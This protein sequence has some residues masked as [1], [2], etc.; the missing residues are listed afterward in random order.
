MAETS[1][2]AVIA[3]A[4]PTGLTAALALAQAGWR[5]SVIEQAPVMDEVGAGLQIPPNASRILQKLGVMDHLRPLASEPAALH[6]RRGRDGAVLARLP[7]GSDAIKRWGA[8]SLVVHR[9]DLQR[10]LLESIALKPQISV[11]TGTRIMGF[12]QQADGIAIGAKMGLISIKLQADL[13]IG[14]DG[15]R[16]LLRERLNLAP[17]DQPHYS[18]R[19]AWRA[20]L[21]A[22]EAPDFAKSALTHLW[23]GS[24][25]HLVHYP[26]RGGRL[27]NIVAITQDDWRAQDEPDLWASEGASEDV[28][29]RFKH[30][31]KEARAL[32]HAVRCWRRWPLY[33]RTRLAHWSAGH[34]VLA[35]DA[36]HPM[37][38][39]L[40][41]GA[42]QGIEDGYALGQAAQHNGANLSRLIVDYESKRIARAYRVQQQSRQQGV[43]YHLPEPVAMM[44]DLTLRVLGPQRLQQRFD[45]LYAP[46]ET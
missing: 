19:I 41:Q 1:L 27:I 40:A 4:G 43:I 18:G 39:F 8:P 44:R 37:M 9:A 16:S 3:G 33:D 32:I 22:D 25:A 7:L 26:L 2:H 20:L 45:W 31:H 12:S 10:A 24:K 23:L 15:L 46:E 28:Q 42:A 30:W 14:A 29:A 36:A 11:K 17:Q 38:P 34:I 35:G 21:P 6:I 5:V 13:L